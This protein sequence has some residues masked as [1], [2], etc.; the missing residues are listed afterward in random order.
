MD[1]NKE[2]KFLDK[3]YIIHVVDTYRNEAKDIKREKDKLFK[4]LIPPKDSE[5]GLRD[6]KCKRSKHTSYLKQNKSEA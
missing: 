1:V 4:F 5:K 6:L 3:V 2:V